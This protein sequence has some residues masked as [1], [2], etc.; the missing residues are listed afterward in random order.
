MKVYVAKILLCTSRLIEV[1]VL[2]LVGFTDNIGKMLYIDTVSNTGDWYR[3]HDYS[4]IEADFTVL[5]VTLV[6]LS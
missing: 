1:F 2:R 4:V 3:K 5:I 6:S